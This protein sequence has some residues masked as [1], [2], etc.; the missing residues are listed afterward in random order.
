MSSSRTLIWFQD[1]EKT[2]NEFEVGLNCRF[3]PVQVLVEDA[4][5][6]TAMPNRFPKFCGEAASFMN[7]KGSKI[8]NDFGTWGDATML[9][10]S[11]GLGKL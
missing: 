10:R 2:T 3:S 9:R 8:T 7:I 4:D 6:K 11:W 5:L 1:R